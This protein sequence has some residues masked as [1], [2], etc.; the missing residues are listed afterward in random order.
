ML[1]FSMSV[2][3][4]F[5]TSNHLVRKIKWK[6]LF[7][8]A[9]SLCISAPGCHQTVTFSGKDQALETVF[10]EIKK[11]TGYF[12]S[13]DHSILKNAQRV[14]LE[15]KEAEIGE[16]LSICLQNQGLDFS[17]MEKKITITKKVKRKSAHRR[18]C[19]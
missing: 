16:V 8:I 5:T 18:R 6:T 11:Q 9:V 1:S 19:N 7:L 12:F 10:K 17:I 15:L 13:Y 2:K 4:V 3:L 14:T